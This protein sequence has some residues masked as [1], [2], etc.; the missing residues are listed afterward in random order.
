MSGEALRLDRSD[1]DLD[2]G[3]LRV[4]HTKFNKS[5]AVP[6][7]PSSVVALVAYD[8]TCEDAFPGVP[9]FFATTKGTRLSTGLY[10]SVRH[11]IRVAGIEMVPGRR[12][13]ARAA[14]SAPQLRRRDP[15]DVVSRR[16]RRSSLACP[17]SRHD[18]GH[19][20][21]GHDLLVLVGYARVVG[22]GGQT[23]SRQDGE[24]AA[25]STLAPCLQAFFT[26]RLITQRRASAHT[27]ASY[28]DTFRLLLGFAHGA[29]RQGAVPAGPGRSRRS[30]D[31]R[32]FGP[33]GEGSPQ[34][35]RHSQHS[36]GCV[37]FVP[38]L[39]GDA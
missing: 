17:C 12:R 31:R 24:V 14:R 29:H 33:S 8:R 16:S 27:I 15:D 1:V 26:E 18:L 25:V 35:C 30:S 28:R 39:C 9:W 6:L 20:E 19:L 37:A 13:P 11:L 4:E 34:R 7:H 3:V 32:L 21:A 5:R 10:E 23:I 38:A 2:R 36:S 22:S